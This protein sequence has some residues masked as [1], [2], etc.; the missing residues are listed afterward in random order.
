MPAGG[1]FAQPQVQGGVLVNAVAKYENIALYP[2]FAPAS[3][4]SLLNSLGKC[5]ARG[6]KS[7]ARSLKPP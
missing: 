1:F 7:I 6:K 4:P 2:F 3:A 5:H